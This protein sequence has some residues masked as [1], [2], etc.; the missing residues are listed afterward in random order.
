MTLELSCELRFSLFHIK[1]WNSV[2]T[3]QN[4]APINELTVFL[5]TTYFLDN[6]ITP[7][8]P[9]RIT[10]ET[11][12]TNILIHTEQ[13]L[14]IILHSKVCPRIPNSWSRSCSNQNFRFQTINSGQTTTI[15]Q[16][17]HH[18]KDSI[19]KKTNKQIRSIVRG[20]VGCPRLLTA[21]GIPLWKGASPRNP[22]LGVRS[23]WL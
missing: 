19:P 11:W 3:T 15:N 1:M 6:H 7:E 22:V 12:A 16:R 17:S 5:C 2:A 23:R 9:S 4:C 10:L 13:L 21:G 18:S 20:T 8:K 14:Q